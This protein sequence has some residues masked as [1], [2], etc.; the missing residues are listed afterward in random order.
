MNRF[1]THVKHYY[2][3]YASNV[4]CKLNAAQTQAKRGKNKMFLSLHTSYY[5]FSMIQ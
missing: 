1:D 3:L 4:D 5:M 2:N